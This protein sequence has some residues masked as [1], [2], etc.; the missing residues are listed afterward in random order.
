[1]RTSVDYVVKLL[2]SECNKKFENKYENKR[3]KRARNVCVIKFTMALDEVE[4]TL[5]VIKKL[6]NVQKEKGVDDSVT[7][8]CIC[9]EGRGTF[10]EIVA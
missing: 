2:K 4:G 5:G 10:H 6:C 8:R 3:K 1:M 7:Y 9:F